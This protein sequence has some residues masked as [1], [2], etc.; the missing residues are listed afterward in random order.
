[1]SSIE[2]NKEELRNELVFK[3]SRSGGKGGQNVNK[4]ETKVELNFDVLNSKVLSN[5]ER[6][7]ISKKLFKKLTSDGILKITSQTS[8]SQFMNKEEAVE[9]FFKIFEKALTPEKKRKDTKPTVAVKEKRIRLKKQRS[10]K[11]VSRKFNPDKE[12]NL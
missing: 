8:R 10:E 11:K 6:E 5:I 2:L 7:L 12:I 1:M 9:K 3:T 4:V